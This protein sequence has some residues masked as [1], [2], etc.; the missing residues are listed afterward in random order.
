MAT[1]RDE[2]DL[3]VTTARTEDIAEFAMLATEAVGRVMVLEAPHTSGP[4]F[5][6]AMVLFKRLFK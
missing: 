6:A 2:D 4:S 1:E 3:F 5:D